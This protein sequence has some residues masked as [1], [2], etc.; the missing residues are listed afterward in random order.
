[1]NFNKLT[2][3]VQEA[4]ARAQGIAQEH[5][6]QQIDVPHLFLA[7]LEQ[8]GG[9]TRPV[10]QQLG[11][12][13][14][15]LEQMTQRIIQSLPQIVLA[16][17][18][19]QIYV[20][21]ALNQVLSEAA[22]QA[23][24][25]GDEYVSSEHLLLAMTEVR[26]PVRDLLTQ[27]GANEEALLS[28]LQTV[29]GNQR[30]VDEDPESKYQALEKYTI[31]L[32]EQVRRGKLDPVIGRDE[33][34]RR[35]VQII[36]RRTKNNPVLIGE[37]GVGKTAIVEG[38]AQRII[39]GDVPESLKGK[40]V[41]ALDLGA[42]IAGSRFRGEFE[43]RLKAVL[44]EVQAAEGKFILF[45]DE[46]HT[47][48]GAGA[49]EGSL[50]AS[51]MLKPALSRGELHAIGATT[52]K[53]YQKYI[54]RDAAFER[55]FQPIVVGEP[56]PE[57]T[58][59]IL[60][61]V[62]ERYEL[63][64]GVRITDP[65]LVAAVHLSRRYINDRFLPDKAIDLIDEATSALRLEIDSM[66]ADL[67]RKQRRLRQL[68]IERQALKNEKDKASKERLK[69][70]EKEVAELQEST[71]ELELRWQR[72]KDAISKIRDLQEQIDTLKVAADKNERQGSLEQ[73]AVIRYAEI[74]KLAQA[75]RDEQAKLD[76]IGKGD[77]I[78]K[79]EV[80]E[81]DIAKVVARW[82]GIPVEKMLQ[83]DLARLANMETELKRRMVGQ[84][85]ALGAV[86]AAVRRSRAGIAD[87]GR[88]IGSFLFLGPTGVGKTELSKALAEFLFHD[89]QA[90][91]RIDMSEYMEKH[92]V[93]RMVGSP[94]GYVG[95][96][97]GGQLAEQIRRRPYAVV[98]FDEIEKAHPE[99]FNI[100]LQILDDGRL[101]DAKGRTVDFKNTV[102]VMT[103]NLGSDIIQNYARQGSNNIGY[104]TKAGAMQTEE[105]RQKILHELEL[106]FR[107][108]FLNRIDEIILFHSL[109]KPD[110]AEI[111]GRQLEKV[112]QRLA[113]RHIRLEVTS[114]VKNHLADKGYDIAYG[115][116][117]LKRAIQTELLD[118]LA[119]QLLEGK[120]KD[121][122]TVEVGMK[123]GQVAFSAK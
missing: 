17:S 22:H 24:E 6:Q 120:I 14:E 105:L 100:L 97:E 25:L 121:G 30:V 46:L 38:L 115:A 117:P 23:E 104:K 27:A 112:N 80:T 15:A 122:Q 123:S 92:A 62:K 69:T 90:L 8:E 53:E 51:N 49:T 86:S 103:S 7:M 20:T 71:H 1:M 60:R 96:D 40:Q 106:A 5:H 118:P 28:V 52:L 66:P 98:L 21:H 58:V 41:I 29:R 108:E 110:I 9:I 35:V 77:R 48:I 64:H 81:E 82:T 11:A 83:T 37:P 10:L 36:S 18:M 42:L 93:A 101:T 43:E 68:E 56:T 75:M 95:F 79:E 91:V 114:A 44:K 3:K 47:I 107:P 57:D 61:G 63:H 59:A 39:S 19:G 89:E 73:V 84:D 111:I 55:R 116:R 26:S 109:S 119:M 67:D 33:E 50:D 87:P 85:E 34:I 13:I 113:E 102:I 76:Q 54:E 12:P 74:P 72:E 99:V 88:P 31:N 94:P 2:L 78:L 4:L 32:T 65:A 16:A 45:I 70:L